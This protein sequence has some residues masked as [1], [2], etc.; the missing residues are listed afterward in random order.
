MIRSNSLI[1]SMENLAMKTFMFFIHVLENGK[2]KAKAPTG[3]QRVLI[4]KWCCM[5]DAILSLYAIREFKRVHADIDIEMLV[6]TRIADI[7]KQLPDIVRVHVL[8]VTGRRLLLELFNPQLWLRFSSLIFLLRRARFD[9]FIDLELY[10]GTGPVLKR[11]LGIPFSRGFQVEGALPKDHDFEVPRARDMLEWQC[12]YLILGLKIPPLN[13]APLYSRTRVDSVAHEKRIGIVY[14]S[15]FN[16]PQK[17]WPWEFFAE[18][19]ALLGNQGFEFLLF[20]D[21]LEK[22]DATRIKEKCHGLGINTIQDTTG[23]LDFSGLRRAVSS[24]D[25]IL[26][27]DTGTLHLASACGIPTVTLFGPTDPGKWNGLTSTPLFLPDL[28][29]R[30]C[31]Y[32]GG[33]PPCSHFSCLRKLPP[34]RVA[35]Q[36][37][38][39]LQDTAISNF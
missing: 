5:G 30:P 12:F 18:T 9:Q 32:L 6:S 37:R 36:I 23:T 26:G 24:C 13:P 17:K 20:G 29:C 31:Y 1:R 25:L 10:R 7:Y 38:T 28:A 16:W 11:L 34:A 8:P 33:M 15:S 22:Q 4:C 21:T 3:R 39:L 14:G 35:E 19:I 27:N 2:P